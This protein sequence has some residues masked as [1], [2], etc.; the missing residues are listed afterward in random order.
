MQEERF[1][2]LNMHK[3]GLK[4]FCKRKGAWRF[5][6]NQYLKGLNTKGSYLL[7]EKGCN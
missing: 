4:H 1:D 7:Q 6:L 2:R 3:A 5:F